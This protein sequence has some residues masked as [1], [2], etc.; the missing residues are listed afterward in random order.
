M[1][2][3]RLR[4]TVDAR[5]RAASDRAAAPLQHPARSPRTAVVV[6]RLL[7]TAFVVCFV[8]GLY[9]HFLQDPL[10]WMRFPTWPSNL[11]QLTQGIHVTTGIASV[12]L[13]LAK[14]WTVYPRLLQWP[15]VRG[16]VH[17]VERGL[18]GVLV[19]AALVEVATGLLNT[20][21]WYPWHFPF[22]GTH[23][24]LA[25]VVV[26]ALAIHV[27]AQLPTIVRHRRRERAVSGGQVSAGSTT[28]ETTTR[29]GLLVA[30]GAGVAAVVLLTAGQ[31]FR[32]LRRT[33][34]F[35]PRV[36]GLGP[37]GLPV[38]KTAAAARVHD[39]ATDPAWTLTVVHG[40]RS[41]ALTRAELAALP[42][43]EVE[44]PIACVEGW[45]TFAR[46]RG[47]RVAD[48][49]ALV[50]APSGTGARV[51]SLEPSGPYRTSDL[52]PAFAHHPRTLVALE[53]GGEPLDLDHG[54][55]ARLIAPARPGVLQT[56]W[57]TRVE[58]T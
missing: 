17:A 49:L 21:Q 41:V 33:N 46:W 8:T 35:A 6:G 14:L 10:P 50:D 9:S 7:G 40:A 32:V 2:L 29:R 23:Y 54:Y 1:R 36:Q 19:A 38:N 57:L 42:Q 11:Y 12:P 47:V 24:A 51:T 55:P 34:L 44:L 53:L 4:D 15:P 31:S 27:A 52:E 16:L 39:A 28:A 13:L 43:T 58:T 5:G 26:G 30:V 25:W 48:L 37:Q 22:R 45:T 18:V 20:Y 3:D 56:K